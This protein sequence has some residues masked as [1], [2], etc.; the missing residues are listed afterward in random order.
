MKYDKIFADVQGN[1]LKSFNK[2][3]QRFIFF[4]V[5]NLTQ[6]IK[7]WFSRFADRIPSTKYLIEA[8]N[9]R[10]K[11]LEM[12]D[13]YNS[14]PF[15]KS[16]SETDYLKNEL[17]ECWAHISFTKNF[18]QKLEHLEL[19]ISPSTNPSNPT[20]D[21]FYQ[22]MVNQGNRIGDIGRDRQAHRKTH[23]VE[24]F[25]GRKIDG[26]IILAADT[27]MDAN[28]ET[29]AL[30]KEIKTLGIKFLSLEVGRTKTNSEGKNIEHFGFRDDISQP[31]IVGIDTDKINLRKEFIDVFE[32]TDFILSGLKRDLAWANNGS[33][34]VF[35]KLGQ[36]VN[37]FWKF[38]KKASENFNMPPEKVAAKFIGRWQSGAP[39]ALYP[40]RDP[41]S[42]CSNLND[43]LYFEKDEVGVRTPRFSHIRKS[44]PR[45]DG[46]EGA[47]E[48]NLIE[49][50]KHRIL[51]RG[52]TYENRKSTYSGSKKGLLFVCYQK[53]LSEQFEFIQRQWLNNPHFP[54]KD[55]R[56]D[57]DEGHGIDAIAGINRKISRDQREG[58]ESYVNLIKKKKGTGNDAIL[59]VEGFMMPKIK[60]GFKQWVH[61]HGGEYFFSPSIS[62]LKSRIFV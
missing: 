46:R 7:I 56:F 12:I 42:K 48:L 21:P 13:N 51:R 28:N 41:G 35:R 3:E 31:L 55:P 52:I 32:P 6:P 36:D 50:R 22:G 37:G 39:L 9:R 44:S 15:S 62:S 53:D 27:E 25:K 61:N 19:P 57:I 60:S 34:M 23:W 8:S 30:V 18:Y 4:E 14:N 59:K 26:V 1:I 2:P 58:T 40:N 11:I 10:K 5:P 54:E 17:R 49:S 47:S 38:M 33:F 24:P 16:N 45:D 20:V 43:F 29:Y